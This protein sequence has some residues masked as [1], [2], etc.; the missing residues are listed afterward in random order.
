MILIEDIPLVDCS[1][2][3]S[4]VLATYNGESFLSEQL[5]SVVAQSYS[6]VEIIISDDASTDSTI[7][8]IKAY[9]EKYGAE[10][11][12]ANFNKE[13]LGYTRNFE[14]AISLSSGDYLVFCDQDDIWLPDK[15][16]IQYQALSEANAL[17][18]FSDAFLVDANARDLDISLWEAVLG[19]SPPKKIDYRAFY[20]TNCVTGCTLMIRRQ[21]LDAALPFP[22]S[23]PHDWWLA[24]HAAYQD[25]LV[26]TDKKLLHYRQHAGNVYG[27]GSK[28]RKKR[29]SYYLRNKRQKWHLLSQLQQVLRGAITGRFRLDAMYEFEVR[30]GS[31]ASDEL[32]HLSAWIDDQMLGRNMSKYQA[33]FQSNTPVFQLFSRKRGRP[34]NINYFIRNILIRFL[35]RVLTVIF[36]SFLLFLALYNLTEYS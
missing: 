21:L 3:I 5:D 7:A 32:I 9:Q 30:S 22:K 14:K 24:Y 4:V 11:I 23:V 17:A 31:A 18:V 26:F 8:I 15:I 12:K 6:N 29:L 35:R 36:C 20:L 2:L 28:I 34:E 10:K 13:N 33:F 1:A 25:R 27:V 19:S 16:A